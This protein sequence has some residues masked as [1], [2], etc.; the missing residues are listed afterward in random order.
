MTTTKENVNVEEKVQ[1]VAKQE[2]AAKE[3]YEVA[4]GNDLELNLADYGFSADELEDLSGLDEL[5]PTDITIPYATMIK[6]AKKGYKLGD[7][8]FADGTKVELGVEGASIDN[9]SILQVMNVRVMFPADFDPSNSFT[10]RSLD[11]KVGAPGAEYEG[12][13]C[14]TCEF[15]K[16]PEKGGASPCRDQ[17]LLLCARE[18]GSLFHLQVHGVDIKEWKMFMSSQVMHLLPLVKKKIGVQMIG[19]L[20]VS[21]THVSADT[22][23]GEFPAISFKINPEDAFHEKSTII[24]N[25][26]ALRSYKEFYQKE[27]LESAAHQAKANIV[28]GGDVIEEAGGNGQN[29]NLF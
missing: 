26:E 29:K 12:R 21:I 14:S 4:A 10:C 24:R 28:N 5:N 1:E 7:F 3:K 9:I 2:E 6:K 25:A 27:S 11:G 15:S 20:K 22:N 19:A 17:R 16:Y 18:D 8:E 13:D 23:F